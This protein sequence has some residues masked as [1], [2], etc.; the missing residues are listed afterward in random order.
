MAD[1]GVCIGGADFDQ[2]DWE[3]VKTLRARKSHRCCECQGEI[4]PGQTYENYVLALDGTISRYKTCVMCVE[5][6]N[7]FCC[8]G[9]WMFTTIWDEMTEYVFPELTTANKCFA[10]LSA[11]AKASLLERWRKWKFERKSHAG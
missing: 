3:N 2:A 11:A 5:I 8:G 9:S 1:C 6:R 10:K 4:A 7:A